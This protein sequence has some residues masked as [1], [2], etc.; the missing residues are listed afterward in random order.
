[1]NGN[2][3]YSKL[4]GGVRGL[5]DNFHSEVE[6]LYKFEKIQLEKEAISRARSCKTMSALK[7][8]IKKNCSRNGLTRDSSKLA[9]KTPIVFQPRLQRYFL[10]EF[11]TG[12][13]KLSE[14][15]IVTLRK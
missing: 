1:M 13:S 5:F 3:C 15:N 7:K 9:L 12:V 10:K 11:M 8:L 14:W 4:P 6:H 2:F